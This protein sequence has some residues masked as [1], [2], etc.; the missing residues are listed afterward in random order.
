[1]AREVTNHSGF[2][3]LQAEEPPQFVPSQRTTVHVAP[4]Q[5]ISI[6]QCLPFGPSH[7]ITQW[8]S[9]VQCTSAWQSPAH[10]RAGAAASLLSPTAR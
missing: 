4:L 7:E 5:S 6:S 1:M 10:V 9:G 3:L 2:V 8:P